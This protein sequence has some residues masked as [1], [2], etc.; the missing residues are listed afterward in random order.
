MPPPGSRCKQPTSIRLNNRGAT[1]FPRGRFIKR[2]IVGERRRR[3]GEGMEEGRGEER[4]V[5]SAARECSHER[6]KVG[7]RQLKN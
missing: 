4:R 5:W 3:D 7:A 1:E 2:Y 6:G